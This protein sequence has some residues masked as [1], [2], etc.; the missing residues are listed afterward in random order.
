MKST[1]CDVPLVEIYKEQ[2][3]FILTFSWKR[4]RCFNSP[5]DNCGCSS[6]ILYQ[7]STHGSLSFK[8]FK[9]LI[10]NRNLNPISKLCYVKVICY[11]LY[12]V[13]MF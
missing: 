5:L 4:K 10:A 2:L 1:C 12:A 8:S 7:N 3:T 6:L 13:W 9:R 11:I